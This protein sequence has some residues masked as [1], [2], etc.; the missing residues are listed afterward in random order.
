MQLS[1]LPDEAVSRN[2]DWVAPVLFA[3]RVL[4][5]L[6]WFGLVEC[7]EVGEDLEDASWRKSALFDRFLRFSTDLVRTEGSMH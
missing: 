4:R 7:R 2:Q 6:W 1:V 5:P 3:W